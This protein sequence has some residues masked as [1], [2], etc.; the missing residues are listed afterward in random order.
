M[1]PSVLQDKSVNAVVTMDTA[2]INLRLYPPTNAMVT[3]SID[4]LQESLLNILEDV[5]S[6]TFAETE[7]NLLIGGEPLGPKHK[8]K[9]HVAIFLVL[10]MNWGIKSITFTR[11]LDKTELV[12]FLE[13]IGKKPDEQKIKKVWE[14]IVSE[15]KMP[16]ILLNQKIYIAKDE[17][18]QLVASLDIKD[19]DIVKYITAEDPNAI[20]DPQKVKEMAQDPE[21]V[22]RI[23]QSG[24]NN[25]FSRAGTASNAKLSKSVFNMLFA[26]DDISANSDKGKISHLIAGYISDMDAELIAMTLA[27]NIESLLGSQLFGDIVNQMD[28]VKFEKVAGMIGQI[29]DRIGKKGDSSSDPRIAYMQQAFDNMMSSERGIELQKR[30]QEIKAREEQEHNR[31]ITDLRETG[32]SILNNL[33]QGILDERIATSFDDI[34]QDLF[35]VGENEIAEELIDRLSNELFNYDVDIRIEVSEALLKALDSLSLKKRREILYRLANKLINW[36]RFETKYTPAYRSLCSHLSDLAQS[37]IQDQQFMDSQPVIETFQLIVSKE[38]E[39]NEEISAAASDT[40][41]EIASDETL[42][43]L[44]QDFLTDRN[45]KRNEAGQI[46]VLMAD[47]SINRLLNI[48]KESEDSSERILI[49]NL[50]PEMGAAATPAVLERINQD[51]PWYYMRNL[52]R[53]LGKIGSDEHSKIVAPHLLHNDH[54]VQKEAVKSISQMGGRSKAEILLNALAECDDR[55][56]AGIVTALGTLKY[57]NAVKPLIELFKSKLTLPEDIKVDLQEKICL[58]LGNIGDKEALPFLK[59]VRKYRSF[60][61]LTSYHPT[62]RAAAAKALGKITSKS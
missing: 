22:S 33:E 59:G 40:L 13:I 16:H 27:Q 57:R 61:A 5:N 34:I 35:A 17:E 37:Q 25:I 46:L 49:L 60:L 11:G 56:K 55:I 15:G 20:L 47:L 4:R 54:R 30:I 58:A 38:L 41:R 21:W 8:G 18:H 2:I 9:A 29:L 10:M 39:K 45:N 3:R 53:L 52:V 24:M 1:M 32:S 23:F 14:Q 12:P 19:D 51:P 43:I 44:I 36:I 28:S 6:V 50:I 48:I 26:V 7:K 62:V 42:N 31:K